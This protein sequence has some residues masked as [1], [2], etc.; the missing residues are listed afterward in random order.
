MVALVS[1]APPLSPRSLNAFHT[2]S[3]SA[4]F[5]LKVRNGS[6]DD[7]VLTTA[8]LP[9]SFRSSAAALYEATSDG[10]SPARSA[11]LSITVHLSS[12]ASTLLPKSEK[13]EASSWLI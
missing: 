10:G 3:R 4:R 2:F 12:S 1:V 5:E 6:T 11:S 7:R 8:H 9:G 13:L